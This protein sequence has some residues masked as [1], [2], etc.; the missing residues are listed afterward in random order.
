M[1]C[2][3][4]ATLPGVLALCAL[5]APLL[6][7]ALAR[8][9]PRAARGFPCFELCGFCAAFLLSQSLRLYPAAALQPALLPPAMDAALAA[10]L[11]TG[12]A[13]LLRHGKTPPHPAAA[14]PAPRSLPRR[15]FRLGNLTASPYHAQ[16]QREIR[17]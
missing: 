14:Q 6:E 13:G 17:K 7:L 5:L 4:P 1:S 3:F 10:L 16:A 12:L 15:A 9:L 2:L 8:L 11:I